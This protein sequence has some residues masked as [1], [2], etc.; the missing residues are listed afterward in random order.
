ML[1]MNKDTPERRALWETAEAIAEEVR[2]WSLWRRCVTT[3]RV[4]DPS[5]PGT[6]DVDDDG[7]DLRSRGT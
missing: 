1:K 5:R 2:T 4:P 7:L 3:V 6:S